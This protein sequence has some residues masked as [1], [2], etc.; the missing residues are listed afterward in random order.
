[1]AVVEEGGFNRATT[2]L[3]M[4]QP[5][6]SYQIKLLEAELGMPLFY[7]RSRGISPTEAGRVLFQHA[8]KIEETVRQAQQALERLTDGVAGEVRIGT[9]NSVGIYFL[10]EIL[11]SM[12]GKFPSARP[13]VLYR[14]SYEIIDAL[15]SN[16]VDLALVAN[17]QPDRRLRQET[18]FEER[19]SLVCSR[20]HPFFGRE[21][22]RPTELRGQPFASLT[23]EN[24]T[25]QLV[26]DY[27]AKLGVNVETV[28]STDNVETVREMVEAGLGVAFL[29]D[30]VTSR[31]IACEG[32]PLGTFSRI[33]VTPPLTRRIVLVTWKQVDP[34]PAVTAFINEL[35]ARGAVWKGCLD[36]EDA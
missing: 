10:P 9:V 33:Q 16:R 30:M 31:G 24:P 23:A 19:V 18:I 27:L 5:A 32:R 20:T 14:N 15:L 1:M 6:I 29:P 17:P 34:T 11:Q 3:H 12:R 26:R 25:G 21:N 8:R 36:S 13:T 35:R 2:R 4:T 28:V 22:I 7:R